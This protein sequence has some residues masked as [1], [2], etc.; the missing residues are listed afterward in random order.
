MSITQ[1]TIVTIVHNVDDLRLDH[2][3]VA[4]SNAI[5]TGG[6]HMSKSRIKLFLS[7]C[8][9]ER[10]IGTHNKMRERCN[11]SQIN[12]IQNDSRAIFLFVVSILFHF[13]FNEWEKRHPKID[14]E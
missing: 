4:Y 13:N 3:D 5:D 12:K 9:D 7:V 1:S 10:R 11:I 6:F 14:F 8:A 2:W